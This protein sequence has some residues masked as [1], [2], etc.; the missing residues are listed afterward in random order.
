MLKAMWNVIMEA[1]RGVDMAHAIFHRAEASPRTFEAVRL[2]E[3]GGAQPKA[4][5]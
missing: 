3:E 1:V 4:M 5:V 2:P